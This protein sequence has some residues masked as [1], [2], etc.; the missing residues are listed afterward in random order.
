MKKIEKIYAAGYDSRIGHHGYAMWTDGESY[1]VF[2]SS[3]E[4]YL[5]GWKHYDHLYL[6]EGPDD[7]R[8]LGAWHEI[9]LS[10]MEK[11]CQERLVAIMGE[12]FPWSESSWG[13]QEDYKE[14][15]DPVTFFGKL[16]KA[17]RDPR[18]F[19]AHL[20]KD[21]EW[22]V[23][24]SVYDPTCSSIKLCLVQGHW[25]EV[26]TQSK[27]IFRLLSKE[28]GEEKFSEYTEAEKLAKEKEAL[29]RKEHARKCGVIARK[30][31]LPF[32]VVLRCFKGDEEQVQ[33]FTKSL[34][35]AFGKAFDSDELYCGR[36]R[37]RNELERL[38][39]EIGYVDPNHIATYILECLEA[40]KI[41][42]DTSCM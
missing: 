25:V 33:R 23:E 14:W 11:C 42:K 5:F 9:K 36:A 13:S 27:K 35:A 12:D 26:D 2:F 31:G 17:Y 4:E 19:Q 15:S 3:G 29:A 21:P 32:V 6:T 22:I 10:A 1:K 28:A 39:I 30:Y 18:Y 40:G 8:C 24:K 7:P 34:K 20:L 41:L 16:S 38:G 37:R